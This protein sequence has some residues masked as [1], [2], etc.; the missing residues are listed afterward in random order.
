[1]L[2]GRTLTGT[3]TPTYESFDPYIVKDLF[4]QN[5]HATYTVTIAINAVTT[6][7]A[8][9]IIVLPPGAAYYVKKCENIKTLAYVSTGSAT[10]ILVSGQ[11]S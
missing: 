6:V 8:T 5:T 1:M 10:T 2:L 7:G 9:D 3:A 11:S 4:I